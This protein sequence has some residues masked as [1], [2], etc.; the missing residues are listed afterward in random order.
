MNTKKFTDNLLFACRINVIYAL[1]VLPVFND[2]FSFVVD[3]DAVSLDFALKRK[4][5]NPSQRV[6]CSGARAEI[7]FVMQ[8]NANVNQNVMDRREWKNI[9]AKFETLAE[10]TLHEMRGSLVNLWFTE[11]V[12]R[13]IY[14][15]KKI[16]PVMGDNSFRLWFIVVLKYDILYNNATR[17][18]I[19]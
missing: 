3:F 4:L 6:K 9:R 16:I 18:Y 19:L 1:S 13:S 2:I 5:W 8:T 11:N 7:T 14:S 15:E 17:G 12:T 10:S